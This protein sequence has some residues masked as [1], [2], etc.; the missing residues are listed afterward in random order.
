MSRSKDKNPSTLCL[1][2]AYGCAV[3]KAE[4]KVNNQFRIVNNIELIKN[5]RSY[6][7]LD[8]VACYANQCLYQPAAKIMK[9][10]QLH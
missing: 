8:M 10:S 4:C 3:E 7:F 9:T 5:I 1:A 6:L 2:N